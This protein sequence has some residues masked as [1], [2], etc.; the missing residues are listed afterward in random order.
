M[1][2]APPALFAPNADPLAPLNVI[3]SPVPPKRGMFI[4]CPGC[5]GRT[6]GPAGC[7]QA[8]PGPR[9]KQLSAANGDRKVQLSFIWNTSSQTRQ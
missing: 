6:V 1:P 4:V 5:A 7:A 8:N 2:P 3:W 9:T